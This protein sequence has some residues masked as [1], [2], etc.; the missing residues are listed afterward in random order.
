M[1]PEDVYQL[2]NARTQRTFM[3]LVILIA[4][5]L[6]QIGA[7]IVIWRK[8]IALLKEVKLLVRMAE[9]HGKI[10]DTAVAR[11]ESLVHQAREVATHA[12]PLKLTESHIL[13]AIDRVPDRTVEKMKTDG[14]GTNL[15]GPK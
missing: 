2:V 7:K 9:T 11:T 10:S 15:G 3:F 6:F 8:V 14:S 1:T 5:V 13:D 4:A 12:R